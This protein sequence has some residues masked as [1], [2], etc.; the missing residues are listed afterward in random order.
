M[1]GGRSTD[2]SNRV[3]R[4]PLGYTYICHAGE[5]CL[6]RVSSGASLAWRGVS[7]SWMDGGLFWASN[8]INPCIFFLLKPQMSFRVGLLFAILAILAAALWF[9]PRDGFFNLNTS[10]AAPEL[11]HQPR[12]YPAR[13][14]VP[15]GPSSPNQMAPPDESRLTMPEVASDPY[16]PNEESAS[17]PERLRHPERMF[18]PAPSNNTAEI[19]QASGIASMVVKQAESSLQSFAPEMAQNGGE[20]MNGIFA[21]DSSEV[22]SFSEF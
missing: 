11:E 5:E 7:D 16:A 21:N 17:M 3:H 22:G 4:N 15:A 14:M 9:M 10:A 18:R 19:G 6:E 20:F 8:K 1:E 13:N 12:L 2:N